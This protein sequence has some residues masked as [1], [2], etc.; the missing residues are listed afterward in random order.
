MYMI[1]WLSHVNRANLLGTV[2]W[3]V[4]VYLL[5]AVVSHDIAATDP[6]FLSI[7][8]HLFLCEK[9]VMRKKED[10]WHSSVKIFT[11]LLSAECVNEPRQRTATKDEE[12]R[13][14]SEEGRRM[15]DI[16]VRHCAASLR[17]SSKW[18]H[19]Q[20]QQQLPHLMPFLL[21]LLLLLLLFFCSFSSSC[22][23]SSF[24]V[25][26]ITCNYIICRA[27]TDQGALMILALPRPEFASQRAC[28]PA[29]Q[30]ALSC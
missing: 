2:P 28:L 26:S 24:A 16:P 5:P 30:S 17:G 29:W 3:F 18:D 4:A 27:N 21:C 13:R 12:R 6:L 10:F 11:Q 9:N 20:P 23:S 1:Y 14:R 15:T 7:S 25:P 22:F 19:H 8:L